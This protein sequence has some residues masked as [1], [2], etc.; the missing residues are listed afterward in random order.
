MPPVFRLLRPLVRD[1]RRAE[2]D[3]SAE[4]TVARLDAVDC[5]AA[6]LDALLSPDGSND[7]KRQS[8]DDHD[9][10]VAVHGL[11]FSKAVFYDLGAVTYR[12]PP[13]RS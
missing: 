9:G 1:G 11:S 4:R 7:D 13:W 2:L 10:N 5:G 6:P 12:F 3:S 8:D